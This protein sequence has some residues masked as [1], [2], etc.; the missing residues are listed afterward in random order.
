METIE[1]EA[2][3]ERDRWTTRW[4]LLSACCVELVLG[5]VH[6]H[7]QRLSLLRLADAALWKPSITGSGLHTVEQSSEVSTPDC[8]SFLNQLSWNQWQLGWLHVARTASLQEYI[9]NW[10]LFDFLEYFNILSNPSVQMFA[11]EGAAQQL[12]K[13][14]THFQFLFANLH[15]SLC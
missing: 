12:Y 4:C 9:N 1:L 14:I 5:V 2:E 15:L 10:W 3:E 7:R 13:P 6:G 8:D 11:I